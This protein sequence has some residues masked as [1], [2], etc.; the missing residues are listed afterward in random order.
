MVLIRSDGE[1]AHDPWTALAD[2]TPVPPSGDIVV[3][4]ERW[5]AQ[6]EE[7]AEHRGRLGLRLR[8]EQ[9]AEAVGSDID[10]FS[11]IALEFPKFSDGRPYSTA[12]LLRERFDFAGELRA[13]GHVLQDQFLFMERCGFDAFEVEDEETANAWARSIEEIGIFYQPAGDARR[14]VGHLRHGAARSSLVG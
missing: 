2:E 7:L 11:L 12:R 13:V 5:Q 1:R 8:A 10:T 14:P 4:L 9:L 3:T 6:R